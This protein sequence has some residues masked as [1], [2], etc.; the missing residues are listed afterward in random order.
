MVVN[1]WSCHY[2]CWA[3]A[4]T[5]THANTLPRHKHLHA[6]GQRKT[7]IWTR[8]THTYTCTH[9]SLAFDLIRGWLQAESLLFW[10]GYHFTFLRWLTWCGYKYVKHGSAVGTHTLITSLDFWPFIYTAGQGRDV[11][12]CLFP[13]RKVSHWWSKHI[14]TLHPGAMCRSTSGTKAHAVIGRSQSS[15]WCACWWAW[16]QWYSSS[17]SW[18]LCALP[19]SCTASRTRTTAFANAGVWLGGENG[20][21]FMI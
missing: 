18:S 15:R 17:S 12:Y 19:R 5:L 1:C 21:Q 13:D 16:L 14:A 4:H 2:T 11:I 8:N 7:G 10:T 6:I 20:V 3:T 9:L